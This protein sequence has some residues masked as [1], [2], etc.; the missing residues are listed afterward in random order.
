MRHFFLLD[1]A[2]LVL[3]SGVISVVY[4]LAKNQPKRSLKT[5]ILRTFLMLTCGIIA[6]GGLMLGI[7]SFL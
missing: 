2:S 3:I 7:S 4:S 6:C 1:V 5:D